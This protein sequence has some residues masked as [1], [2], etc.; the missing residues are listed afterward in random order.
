V[1]TARRATQLPTLHTTGD[2]G[3]ETAP[4]AGR[5]DRR[6][7]RNNVVAPV[8]RARCAEKRIAK[9]ARLVAL[10]QGSVTRRTRTVVAPGRHLRDAEA[11][12]SLSQNTTASSYFYY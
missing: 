5:E 3:A 9:T 4:D 11:A 8:R 6:E 7:G 10:E 1:P 2:V 12:T